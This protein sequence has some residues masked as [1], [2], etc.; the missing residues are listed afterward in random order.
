MTQ[1]QDIARQFRSLLEIW[2]GE[3]SEGAL[4]AAPVEDC[5]PGDLVFASK[6]EQLRLACDKRASVIIASGKLSLPTP[7]SS[8][9]LVFKTPHVGLAMAQILPMFDRKQARWA[10][11][12]IHPQSFVHPTAQLGKNVTVEAF[13]SIGENVHIGEGSFIGANTV[14]E[15]NA[16]L[17]EKCR[18]HPQVFIGS[19]SMIGNECEL[20]PH[21]TLGSDGFGYAQDASF[22]HHKLPQLGKVVLGDR[23]E[24][25]AGT[26]VD[27]AAFRETK[28]GSGTKI[29]NLCHIAHNCEIGE[30]SVIAGGFMVAGSSKIGARFMTGGSTVVAD[31]LQIADGVMLAGRSTV[32]NHID[33]PGAYGGYPLAPMKEHLRTVASLPHVARLR[34]QVSRI[35][36]HLNLQEEE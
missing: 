32:T 24:I 16:V 29:D 23:V 2:H 1:S 9:T 8:E 13:A 6:Q 4:K 34:K 11:A 5:G 7:L 22:H 36:K 33:K 28:I 20:Q 21:V 30:N 12:G 10:F 14:I 35:L 3:P 19:D 17:G 31:H 26:A 15:R 25:G 18:I 27:R